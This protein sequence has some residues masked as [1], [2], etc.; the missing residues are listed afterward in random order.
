MRKS[1][2]GYEN[3]YEVDEEG[4]VY[5]LRKGIII[6][7]VQM[8][9]GYLYAHLCNGK[10]TKFVRIHRLVAEAF[11]PNPNKYGQVNHINGNKHDNRVA[12][13]EWCDGYQNM[14]H[15]IANGLFKPK[16]EDNPACKLSAE[17]VKQI[18]KEYQHGSHDF[19]TR[20]LGKKYGVSSVMIGKIVRGENWKCAI[21]DGDV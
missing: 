21:L 9:N 17:I 2:P 20:A 3:L 13:L 10:K 11:L 19:G 8:Q 6:K 12:N 15:A 7:P 4:Y 5:S 14:S 1:I 16:G 18:R